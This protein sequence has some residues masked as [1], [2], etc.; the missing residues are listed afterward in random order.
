MSASTE[1]YL[2]ALYTL[3]RGGGAASTSALSKRL[4]FAAPSVTE[5]MK[6]LA[7][8]G[9]VNYSRYQGVTLTKKGFEMSEKM[10]RKHRLLERFLH[11]T[12][13]IGNDKVHREACAMEHGLSDEAER[14]LCQTLKAPDTCPDDSEVIP[15]CNLGFS[16]CRDCQEWGG[17]DLDGVGKRKTSVVPISSLK[18]GQEGTVAFV[19]GGTEVLPRLLDLGLMPGARVSVS[20]AGPVTEPVEVRVKNSN[21]SVSGDLARNV[22]VEE[23]KG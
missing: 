5:M 21:L 14:A 17:R 13:R 1:E 20:R 10:T 23:T 16:T 15:A 7:A 2:E 9:Y 8:D 11:D 3:T 6:K 4:G 19:R 18:E 22:F 12:L